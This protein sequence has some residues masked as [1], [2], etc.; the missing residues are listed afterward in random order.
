M[1]GDTDKVPSLSR[2]PPLFAC[3]EE[4]HRNHL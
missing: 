4:T 1:S 2:F 3:I